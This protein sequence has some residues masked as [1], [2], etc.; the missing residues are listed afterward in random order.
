MIA[1]TVNKQ[2]IGHVTR[3]VFTLK[4]DNKRATNFGNMQ[5][6]ASGV[7]YA[8]NLKRACLFVPSTYR[9][10]VRASSVH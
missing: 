8:M 4:L 5:Q 7:C 2:L 9:A 1:L 6:R 10:F 3:V